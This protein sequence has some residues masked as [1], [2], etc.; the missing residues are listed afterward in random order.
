MIGA[1]FLS[2][3][4]NSTVFRGRAM[5]LGDE[6]ELFRE[7]SSVFDANETDS[8]D[9]E[10]DS[11]V[12]N[13]TLKGDCRRA[14]EMVPADVPET[15]PCR[16]V[17]SGIDVE[18]IK[19]FENDADLVNMVQS[20]SHVVH[21]RRLVAVR[22]AIV[23]VLGVVFIIAARER[24]Y[25][26]RE[27]SLSKEV[28]YSVEKDAGAMLLRSIASVL[29]LIL[30]CGISEYSWLAH[31][32]RC[33]ARRYLQPTLRFGSARGRWNVCA[34]WLFILSQPWV[35]LQL[36]IC[37][38]HEPPIPGVTQ[39]VHTMLQTIPITVSAAVAAQQN[40]L[41]ATQRAVIDGDV[42]NPWVL[43][44]F[45]RLFLI[46]PAAQ[47][48]YYA[49]G[50]RILMIWHRF[51]LRS[52]FTLR[53]ILRAHPL[54]FL[55]PT[56]AVLVTALSYCM[57]SCERAT[58]GGISSMGDAAWLTLISLFTIGFGDV[59]PLTTC[60]R[61]VSILTGLL[62]TIVTALI[63]GTIY[64][65]IAPS[66]GE[67]RLMEFLRSSQ[68]RNNLNRKAAS[69]I[70]N[71]WR[72]KHRKLRKSKRGGS[73]NS[74]GNAKGSKMRTWLL[75]RHLASSILSL[76]RERMAA[77]QGLHMPAD[78]SSTSGLSSLLDLQRHQSARHRSVAVERAPAPVMT[79][80]QVLPRQLAQNRV[81]DAELLKRQERFEATMDETKR[82][83][84]GLSIRMDV[85]SRAVSNLLHRAPPTSL[86]DNTRDMQNRRTPR[87]SPRS[88][89][90]D[91]QRRTQTAALEPELGLEGCSTTEINE[92]DDHF[93]PLP[94][95]RFSSQGSVS[96]RRL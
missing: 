79:R 87:A 40:S 23:A 56:C 42:S 61:T 11:D 35:L 45:L 14:L 44:C 76:E 13:S 72:L 59:F 75:Q 92:H 70:A 81:R 86:S 73:K 52:S 68:H 74:E 7:S 3:R 96:F 84:E 58:P 27:N 39:R 25:H 38:L 82:V 51:E 16:R 49:R 63:V 21:Q 24:D 9:I 37:S 6:D 62:S 77:A 78:G 12:E 8:D 89:A 5:K 10:G 94:G 47:E 88:R 26:E 80:T 95:Q 41:S 36:A 60:G 69:V 19:R 17:D 31:R 53:A 57:F 93:H 90:R 66:A 50:A 65:A 32:Y 83:L 2:E 55:L 22:N 91:K 64:A 4:K 28:D 15:P 20:F 46:L 48:L 30:L 67:A 71:A 1:V 34:K 29:T 85:L 33:L 43:L 54:R 18:K